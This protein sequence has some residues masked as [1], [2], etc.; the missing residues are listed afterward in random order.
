MMAAKEETSPL[1]ALASTLT[2]AKVAIPVLCGFLAV[3][4]V[5]Q[6]HVEV[7]LETL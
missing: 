4:I 7:S 6:M 5:W 1:G 2:K 3:N